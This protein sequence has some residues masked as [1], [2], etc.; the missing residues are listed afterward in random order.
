V[1]KEVNTGQV[2]WQRRG[3]VTAGGGE[4]K[5]ALPRVTAV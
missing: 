3:D 1:G 5:V 2:M 4:G